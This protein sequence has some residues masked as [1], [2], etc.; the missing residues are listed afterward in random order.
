MPFTLA[1]YQPMQRVYVDAI[2]PIN[3][4]DQEHKHI[5]VFIDSFSRMVMLVPLI[6]VNSAEFL[7]AFNYWNDR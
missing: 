7:K 3:V 1:T 5:L 6:S 4:E 2:G